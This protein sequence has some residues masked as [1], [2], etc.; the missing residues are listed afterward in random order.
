ML[1]EEDPNKSIQ[2]FITIQNKL[3]EI[4]MNNIKVYD[5]RDLNKTILSEKYD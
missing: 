3:S 2:N 5:L 1:S 4:D